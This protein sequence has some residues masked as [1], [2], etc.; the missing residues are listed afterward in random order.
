M[1]EGQPLQVPCTVM[2][3]DEPITLQWYKDDVP[4]ISSSKFM[5]NT[6][7]SKMSMLILQDAG[8]EHSGTYSCKAFNPVGQA[9]FTTTLEVMGN[10]ADILWHGT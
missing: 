7:T 8:S 3:G 9:T 5:I 4:L 2:K 6:I 1:N 10:P